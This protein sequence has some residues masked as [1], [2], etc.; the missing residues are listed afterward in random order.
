MVRRWCSAV[1]LAPSPCDLI[2]ARVAGISDIVLSTC[3]LHAV[4]RF[5]ACSKAAPCTKL[6][7]SNYRCSH[8]I[9]RELLFDCYPVLLF[10]TDSQFISV[11]VC[12][13]SVL[14]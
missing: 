9:K 7:K 11:N 13:W 2:H 8:V 10:H 3:V 6:I 5:H 14:V 1:C 12:V 4:T